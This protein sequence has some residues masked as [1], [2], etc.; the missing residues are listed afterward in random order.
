MVPDS[1]ALFSFYESPLGPFQLQKSNLLG[2]NPLLIDCSTIGP[3]KA[4]E[5]AQKCL[6]YNLSFIDAPVSGGVLGAQNSTLTF[7]V[8]AE[9]DH[10]K[11]ASEILK[12][13]GQNIISCGTVGTGQIA[14]ICN[15]LALGIQMRSI[16]EAM[17]L[18]SL[19]GIDTL[20]LKDI[21]STSTSSCWSLNKNNPLPG[22]DPNSPSSKNYKGGYAASL[23]KKDLQLAVD[24]ADSVGLELEFGELLL[25][26]YEGLCEQGWGDKDFGVI[27]EEIHSRN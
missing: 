9:Q 21:M 17:K 20:K 10:F 15:N 18:G 5:M 7:M 11:S 25:D 12:S 13:M 6:Q 19:L 22:V 14:K 4:R 27:I 1:K 24:C 16:A 3:V 2:S 26:K 23:M 8:G